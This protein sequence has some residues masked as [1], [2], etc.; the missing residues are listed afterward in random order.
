MDNVVDRLD[1]AIKLYV[2]KLTRDSLDERE[3]RRAMEIISFTINLEHIGDIIDKNLC[4]LAGKKIKRRYQFSAEGA[5]ELTAFHKRVL[6]SLQAAFGIFMTRRRRGGPTAASRKDRAAQS[7]AGSGRPAFR[8]AARGP[9]G[10]PGDDLT[11]S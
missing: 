8:A 7:R 4:E 5:A 6:E 1:D 9:A 2:T 10:K 3:G 11:A